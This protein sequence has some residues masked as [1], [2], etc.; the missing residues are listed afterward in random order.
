[1]GDASA[2]R[3]R[4]AETKRRRSRAAI[5]DAASRLYEEHGWLPTTVEAIATEAGVGVVTVYNHFP[6]KNLIAAFAFLPVV[7]DLL[8]DS[9][10]SDAT[11]PAPE[12]LRAF[13]EELVERLRNY[14]KLTIAL[15]E[16]INDFTARHG[17][18]VTPD[19]PRYWVPLPKVFTAIISRGQASGHF[20]AYPPAAEAGPFFSD[21]LLLRVLTRPEESATATAR[22]ILTVVMRTLGVPELAD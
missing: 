16:A 14:T 19:D 15:L 7:S 5:L 3:Q 13:I 22:L 9:R 10:W 4:A 18:D 20:I 11:L 2:A 21:V 1:M 8:E 6:N 12:A 17:T